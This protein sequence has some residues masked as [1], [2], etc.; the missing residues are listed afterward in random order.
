[1][2]FL[3]CLQDRHESKDTLCGQYINKPSRTVQLMVLM[4]SI[5]TR[6]LDVLK[7]QLQWSFPQGQRNKFLD[8]TCFL[9]DRRTKE[10]LDRVGLAI[11]E[12]DADNP[13]VHHGDDFPENQPTIGRF[14]CFSLCFISDFAR[15]D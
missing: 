13:V 4:K 2:L 8:A 6:D 1:M 7:F 9:Y 12:N 14:P 5:E 15:P 3:D 11:R 10:K